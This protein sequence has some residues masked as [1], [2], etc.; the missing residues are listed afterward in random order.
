MTALFDL[1]KILRAAQTRQD[2]G[3]LKVSAALKVSTLFW[4][5]GRK[6]KTTTLFNTSENKIPN[7]KNIEVGEKFTLPSRFALFFIFKRAIAPQDKVQ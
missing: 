7:M 2:G 5:V 4:G 3:S 1:R 6:K